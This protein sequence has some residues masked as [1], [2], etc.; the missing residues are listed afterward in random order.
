[1][2]KT[3]KYDHLLRDSK[4]LPFGRVVLK[5][6]YKEGENIEAVLVEIPLVNTNYVKGLQFYID[7]YK[8]KIPS[9]LHDIRICKD[10]LRWLVNTFVLE[11][12]Q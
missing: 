5:N 7:G 11:R 10:N 2:L 8:Y 4:G 1:M 12:V 6:D 9:K 3:F